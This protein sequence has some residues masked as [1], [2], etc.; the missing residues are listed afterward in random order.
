MFQVIFSYKT[1]MIR[2][3]S[4]FVVA[5]WLQM[6]FLRAEL[7]L[8]VARSCARHELRNPHQTCQGSGKVWG[9]EIVQTLFLSNLFDYLSRLLIT[10]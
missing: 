2:E 8:S 9:R 7:S 3:E 6:H 1:R 10:A 5:E 4:W